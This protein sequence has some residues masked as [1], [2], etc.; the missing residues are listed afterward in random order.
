MLHSSRLMLLV[1]G[2]VQR[3]E[4]IYPLRGLALLLLSLPL[5]VPRA[6]PRAVQKAPGEPKRWLKR[7]LNLFDQSGEVDSSLLLLLP[8]PLLLASQGGS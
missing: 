6:V 4:E 5:L 8:L 1:E 2:Q 7:H 3:R